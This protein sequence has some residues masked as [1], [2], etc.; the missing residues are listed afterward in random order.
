[1]NRGF[2]TIK[3]GFV[4]WLILLAAQWLPAQQTPLFLYTN[5][6]GTIS[7]YQNGQML[8]AGHS[9][10]LTACAA[11]GCEFNK[12]QMVTVS[13]EVKT[14]N[15]PS[16]LTVITTNTTVIETDRYFYN[17]R[18]NF[19]AESSSVQTLDDHPGTSRVTRVSGWRANFTSRQR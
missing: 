15:Y 16:G 5:G 1:M 12:W 19:T 13:T 10:V 2:I 11:S 6:S 9:Y 8:E 7:P 14:V 17:A 18:L 4:L 3:T